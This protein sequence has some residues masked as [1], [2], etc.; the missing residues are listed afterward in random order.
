MSKPPTIA[1]LTWTGGLKFS[2]TIQTAAFTLDSAGVDA[3]SPVGAVA[4][5]LAGCMGMDVVHVLTRGRHTLRA[6]SA[7]LEG[8]RSV[9]DPHRFTRIRLHFVIDGDVPAPAAERAIQLSR[10]KYCSVWH[11]MRQD[12]EFVT[13][14]T[15]PSADATQA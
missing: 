10:D 6:L 13:S 8:E 2:A 4:A 3:P 1:D 9:E 12:I 5:A 11:S 14:F 15:I 7:H